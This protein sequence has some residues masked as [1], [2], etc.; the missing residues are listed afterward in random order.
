MNTPV[1]SLDLL[2]VDDHPTNRLLLSQQLLALGHRVSLA[3]DGAEGLQRWLEEDFAVVIL[4]CH[5]PRMNGY[6]LATAIRSEETRLNRR[7]C[8]LLGYTA[9]RCVHQRNRCREAGMDDC[10]FKPLSLERLAWHL[11]GPF[12]AVADEASAVFDPANLTTMT[13]GDPRQL[14]Y[15]LE[16][17][18]RGCRHDRARLHAL[19]IRL[20]TA[21]LEMTHR[22]LGAARVVGAQGVIAACERLQASADGV[23]AS[24][25]ATRRDELVLALDALEHS[26]LMPGL[27]A[28]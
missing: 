8:R 19:D 21:L 20:G 3:S 22:I 12:H 17:I 25:L 13:R 6:Q 5:M 24:S 7:P 11:S 18:L 4:D 9:A 10:L 28:R 1:H 23:G 15:L 14:E 16:E 27:N 2:L 26:L